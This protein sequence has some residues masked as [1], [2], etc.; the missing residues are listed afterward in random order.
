V[1]AGL[2]VGVHAEK[3]IKLCA[4]RVV[5]VKMA[6]VRTGNWLLPHSAADRIA[7]KKNF[8]F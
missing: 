5:F 3:K 7:R 6:K 2:P 4:F 8:G 1:G